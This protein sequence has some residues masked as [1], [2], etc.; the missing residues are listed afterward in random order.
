MKVRSPESY[1]IKNTSG[2]ASPEIK[3]L[4]RL[5][6][7]PR[8]ESGI[9]RRQEPD[10]AAGTGPIRNVTKEDARENRRSLKDFNKKFGDKFT[11][12]DYRNASNFGGK[13]QGFL[14]RMLNRY[15]EAGA[16]ISN[17]VLNKLQLGSPA[18]TPTPNVPINDSTVPN[19]GLVNDTFN[20]G[21][22]PLNDPL[23][24]FGPRV[25][26]SGPT[27]NRLYY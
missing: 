17:R 11:M 2:A 13:G 21:R 26:F 18:N 9:T 5:V 16:N 1:A 10:F 12:Q 25:D 6:S 8:I 15:Q 23:R 7:V 3:A 24:G 4:R 22:D 27:P 20:V 19:Y 14:K